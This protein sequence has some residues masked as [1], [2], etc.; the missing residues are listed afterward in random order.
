VGA[1]IA[2]KSAL[3]AKHLG[4]LIAGVQ[5]QEARHVKSLREARFSWSAEHSP[6]QR[7][8]IFAISLKRE[9]DMKTTKGFVGTARKVG[10]A[11]DIVLAAHPKVNGGIKKYL[12]QKQVTVYGLDVACRG[13]N[14]TEVCTLPSEFAATKAL[15]LAMLR[16]YL[17][18]WWALQYQEGTVVL[19]SDF[20]DVF[21]QADPFAYKFNECKRERER[22]RET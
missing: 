11:G 12:Q 10:F 5:Q 13:K 4:K 21:F 22:E 9:L 18:Q 17:Y 15:P 14:P 3:K 20:R 8:A 6:N 16:F 2:K 19:L 7:F 1:W